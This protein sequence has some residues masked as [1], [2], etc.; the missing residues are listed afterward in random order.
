MFQGLFNYDN[1]VWRFIGKFGDLIILNI[2]WL[3]CSIPIFTVGASTTAVYY[4]TLKLVRDE[5]GYTIRS[6]FR[7]FK[8]NFKQSTIIWLIMLA[9]GL[10]LFFDLRFF[11]LVMTGNSKVR[12]VLTAAV[13]AISI[14]WMFIF[15]YVFP[16][17]CRFYNPVKKTL[18]NA[19]FMSVRHC[20][21]TLGMI[22]I[23]VVMVIAAYLS[24]YYAPQLTVLVFLFGFPLIAFVN[25]YILNGIFKKYMPKD[26]A[27]EDDGTL[28][29]ILEDVKL[30]AAPAEAETGAELET[31]AKTENGV[32]LEGGTAPEEKNR[33]E[34]EAEPEEQAGT[35]SENNNQD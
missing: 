27:V 4:V 30:S 8:E 28:R 23:D 20:F 9:T 24:L 26:A 6:F 1:P 10:I 18:F 33:A 25:S 21:Q 5:D 29:P 19:F 22:V 31:G 32:N 16:L 35:E 12:I 2:L 14:I 15:S 17:Q 3:I 7:S 11:L 13:G 34:G